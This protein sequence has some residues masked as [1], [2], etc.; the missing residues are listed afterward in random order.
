MKMYT[1]YFAVSLFV[2]NINTGTI[3]INEYVFKLWELK[4]LDALSVQE[5]RSDSRNKGAG[6]KRSKGKFSSANM[7]GWESFSP[8]L[9]GPCVFSLKG[10]LQ[11]H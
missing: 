6:E 10:N 7:L 2:M 11:E 4:K 9:S 3:N 8:E 5:T 1:L